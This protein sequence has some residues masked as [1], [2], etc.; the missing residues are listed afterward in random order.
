MRILHVN[1]FL[2]RKGGAEGYME[3]LAALQERAGHTVGFWGM[4]HPQNTHVELADTFPSFVEFDNPPS[5]V[6]ERARMVGRMIWCREAQRGMAETIE[7]FRPDVAHLHNVYHQ[8]SPSILAPLHAAAVPVVL[9]LHDYKLVCPTY[10]LLDHGEPCTACVGGK[11]WNAPLKRCRNGSLLASAKM[12]ADLSVHTLARSYRHVDAFIC[13]S[14]FLAGQMERGRVY[15]DR[16]HVIRHFVD[17]SG[18][19]AKAAPGGHAVIAGRI[20]AEK[21]ID[22]AIRA[23]GHLPDGAHLDIAGDGPARA[24]LEAFAGLE[25]PGRVTFHGRLAKDELH[26]LLRRSAVAVVPS[27]WYENQPM[28]VLEA[29][30]VGLPVIGSDLG[31]IPELIDAG[32]DGLLVPPGDDKALATAMGELLTDRT[33]AWAMGQTGRRKIEAEFP[34]SLH[35]DHVSGLYRRIGAK[36]A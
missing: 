3:D 29:L 31:G 21:G 6:V 16:M 4:D 14:R 18:V 36:G 27:T 34:P 22:V 28:A 2:F 12:A 13:P 25:A 1:K 19:A 15:P 26:D 32:Q 35:L 20:S 5:G 10:Q 33:R 30:A 9:T 7:R 8:L 24:E 11:F 23:V 17:L